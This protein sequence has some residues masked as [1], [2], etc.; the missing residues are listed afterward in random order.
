MVSVPIIWTS[1]RKAIPFTA[2]SAGNSHTKIFNIPFQPL[3]L[4]LQYHEFPITNGYFT[5]CDHGWFRQW[6]GSLPRILASKENS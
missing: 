2:F 6:S 1:W 4:L 3:F 5:A